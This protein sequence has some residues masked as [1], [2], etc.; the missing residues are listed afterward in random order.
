MLSGKGKEKRMRQSSAADVEGCM[1]VIRLAQHRHAWYQKKC[2]LKQKITVELAV[3]EM[4]QNFEIWDFSHTPHN[5]NQWLSILILTH[6]AESSSS[7]LM[8]WWS[9]SNVLNKGDIQISGG[10]PGLGLK[11]TDL[12]QWFLTLWSLTLVLHR[13]R[14]VRQKRHLNCA[15]F[16]K[17]RWRYFED[18]VPD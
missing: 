15:A 14:C 9:E 16:E 1:H 10:S 12:D 3:L 17:S 2:K 7:H 8:S 18:S 4:L 5:L 6:S 11:T 13:P